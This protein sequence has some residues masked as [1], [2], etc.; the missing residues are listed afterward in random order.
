MD[1]VLISMSEGQKMQRYSEVP[2]DI[3]ECIYRD[4][5]DKE[6]IVSKILGACQ[7]SMLHSFVCRRN[8][9]GV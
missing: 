9:E 3:M 8:T 5:M 7:G 4:R 6:S 2:N 1:F